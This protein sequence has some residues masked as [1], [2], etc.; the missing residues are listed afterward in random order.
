M[1]KALILDCD[2]VL[3]DTERDGHLRAF[4]ETFALHGLSLC[5]SEEEYARLLEI[6]GGKERLKSAL[7]P[8]VLI[9]DGLP[10][11]EDGRRELIAEMHREKTARYTT[12]V[13]EGLLPA[14]PG[15]ARV[16]AEAHA[17]GWVLAVASTSAEAS[18]RAVLE[19]VMGAELAQCFAVF[20]GDIV[21]RKKPAPDIYLHALARLGLA[22]TD[23]V[24][25]EDS[26]TGLLASL[27]AGLTTIVTT[28]SFTG[29]D[30]FTGAALVVTSL[31]DDDQE[32]TVLSNPHQLAIPAHIGLDVL[33]AAADAAH[34][35]EH[36]HD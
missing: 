12:L 19:H 13:R 10:Q 34:D 24:V 27:A 4:N 33:I 21:P 31:G 17:A 30:D 29:D 3:A 6:G 23:A 36:C 15:I 1:P 32:S 20:A 7:V 25:I 28:S 35:Q 18:V 9:R 14:R 22:P 11:D 2:G 16:A 5:W 26:R 8:H